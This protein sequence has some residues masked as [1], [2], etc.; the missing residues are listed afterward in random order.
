[1]SNTFFIND[2]M[3]PDSEIAFKFI[4]LQTNPLPEAGERSHY[5]DQTQ[6]ELMY[7]AFQLQKRSQLIVCM[8]N[9][10]LSVV[11]MCVNNPYRSP[12]RINR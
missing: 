6:R 5:T 3:L 7:R 9:E 10:T 11:A 1:M 12:L 8:H 4:F 2:E